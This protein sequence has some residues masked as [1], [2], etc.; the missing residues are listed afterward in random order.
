MKF[1]DRHG[2]FLGLHSQSL[3]TLAGII[4]G[5]PKSTWQSLIGISLNSYYKLACGK[6]SELQETTRFLT[7]GK[8]HKSCSQVLVAVADFLDSLYG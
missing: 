5:F 3:A 8:R 7:L 2:T 6:I 1:S 4:A